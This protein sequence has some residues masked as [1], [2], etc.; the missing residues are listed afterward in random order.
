MKTVKTNILE[1]VIDC[2]YCGDRVLTWDGMGK[3]FIKTC[4]NCG[5]KIKVE[6]EDYS[7]YQ[8]PF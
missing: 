1:V 5:N 3:D 4:N 2:P 7:E 8:T 6:Y